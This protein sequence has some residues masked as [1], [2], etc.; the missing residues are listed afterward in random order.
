MRHFKLIIEYD[1]TEYHGWQV[2]P[3]GPTVQGSIQAALERI[4]G[5]PVD[6]R[7]AGRTDAGVHALGQVAS[8]SAELRLDA[9]TLRRALN[10]MLPGDVTIRQAEE[11]DE[12]FDARRSAT[13]R[14]YRYTFLPRDA[15]SALLGR[16]SLWIPWP[17]K[18]EA[19][20]EAA[21]CLVGT[22][23][24]SAFRA[25]T[26]TATSPIRTVQ[27]IEWGEAGACRY[28]EITA[29]AFL[30]QMVRILVGTLLEVGR[31][32]RPPEWVAEVLA[33]RDRRR[34]AKAAPPHGLCLMRV[35]YG[36]RRMTND[37]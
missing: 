21:R 29:N 24:F 17:V 30:Q 27:S 26:C 37:Q 2:Q 32:R 8:F 12:T 16:Y 9:A 33:G 20:T 36:D 3:V 23:D 22:H 14:T 18:W 7:G 5:R 6:V 13:A 35:E 10:A 11:V 34:A 1:G 28:L 25:G 31:G 19:M 4:A 15:P